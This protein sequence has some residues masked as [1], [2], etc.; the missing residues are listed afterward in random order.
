MNEMKKMTIRELILDALI[1]KHVVY[2]MKL[3]WN[4]ENRRILCIVYYANISTYRIIW[5]DTFYLIVL[6]V[7]RWKYMLKIWR[8][9]Y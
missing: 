3:W 8:G 7:Y 4:G 9:I 2:Q 5:V 1:I 6:K